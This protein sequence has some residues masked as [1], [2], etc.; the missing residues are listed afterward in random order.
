M[1]SASL[2]NAERIVLVMVRCDRAH[3]SSTGIKA[4]DAY[5]YASEASAQ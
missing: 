3:I 2:S 5:T 4:P 1:R